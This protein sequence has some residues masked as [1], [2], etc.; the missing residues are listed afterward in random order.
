MTFNLSARFII[1][2]PRSANDKRHVEKVV[3]FKH[4]VQAAVQDVDVTMDIDEFGD[5]RD[6]R[7]TSCE[8]CK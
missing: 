5:D 7:K 2:V 4:A 3:C 8:E 1:H 6:F